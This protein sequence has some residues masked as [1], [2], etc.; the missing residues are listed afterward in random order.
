MILLEPRRGWTTFWQIAVGFCILGAVEAL[1]IFLAH[2][3]NVPASA[4]GLLG[5][6]MGAIFT[7]GGIVIAMA[8]LYSLMSVRQMAIDAVREE[9]AKQSREAEQ[10]I[11]TLLQAYDGFV[12]TRDWQ[13][14]V[15]KQA[16]VEAISSPQLPVGE[17]GS[18]FTH[19]DVLRSLDESRERLR[20]ILSIV[21]VPG[22]RL[23]IGTK[24][25]RAVT[26]QF[27]MYH[28]TGPGRARAA[29]QPVLYDF[30]RDAINWMDGSRVPVPDQVAEG[31]VLLGLAMLHGVQGQVDLMLQMVDRI[32][33]QGRWISALE[34]EDVVVCCSAACTTDAQ[35]ERL[36]RKLGLEIP[37]TRGKLAQRVAL[38]FD[39]RP[40]HSIDLWVLVREH[41]RADRAMPTSPGIVRL[42]PGEAGRLRA[43]WSPAH[44]RTTAP[45]TVG[46]PPWTISNGSEVQDEQLASDVLDELDKRFHVVVER[47]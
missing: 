41:L 28:G 22:A 16:L 43:M 10:H 40:H 15:E 13:H 30:A 37:W 2:A 36:G 35:L 11:A 14:E 47:R 32:L 45:Y 33:T 20:D 18:I 7:A 34:Q 12:Q 5:G 8:S 24:L 46:I 21:E 25:H 26:D 17:K 27:L 4:T 38:M 23:W 42:D 39:D 6:I 19:P 31:R 29:L 9:V 44:P 3:W 1:W